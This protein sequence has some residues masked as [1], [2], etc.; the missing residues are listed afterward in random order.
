MHANSLFT[1]V[2]QKL[3]YDIHTHHHSKDAE[4]TVSIRSLY[5]DFMQASSGMECTLGLHPWYLED[6]EQLLKELE[7]FA[8]L[9]NVLAIGECGLDK[10]CHSDWDLQTTVFAKQITLANKLNKPLIIHC[11][12]AFDELLGA[13]DEHEP[14]VPV[15]VHGFN[16][17]SSIADKLI[18]HRMYLS[19]G[20][21]I[22]KSESPAAQALKHIPA[23]RFFLETDN[24]D[25]GIEDIYR[26]AAAIREITIEAVILQV[27]Q[28]FTT[29][30]KYIK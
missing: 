7:Q 19:F 12:R 17:K 4:S 20:N 18:A 1:R 3:Y 24:A 23:D 16:K 14:A 5:G 26:A 28:N 2:I 6:C 25:V 11:V 29:V 21:A 27:Q 22:T 30:F 13:F 10:L 15:I 8:G 9:P